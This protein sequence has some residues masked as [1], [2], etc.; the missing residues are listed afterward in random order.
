[1]FKERMGHT[2]GY[3][4]VDLESRDSVIRREETNF[5]NMITDLM[6][7][8]YDADFGFCISGAFRKNAVIPEGPI[9]LMEIQ[10]SFPFNDATMVLEMPGHIVKEALEWAVS[11]YPSE[12]GRSPQVSGLQFW[13][14]P[15]KPVGRRICETE[16]ITKGQGNFDLNKS[17][18]VAMPKFMAMGGDGYSMFIGEEVETI[19]DEENGLGIIDIVK[20]FFKR[21]RT[22]Y[23][24]I[25]K[26]ELT[27]QMR[28]RV[29]HVDVE[30]EIDGVSPDGLYFKLYPQ[31]EG[32]ILVK[33]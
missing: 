16:I 15:E 13:F 14:D 1:M 5:G 30:D 3:V 26:R 7:T 18:R 20:Q 6:R 29:F 33:G 12:E 10:A 17:Y 23:Q 2:V 8:E 25:A 4:G 19:V 22:D 31:V 9:S 32:R 27:R 24:V 11:A 28:L 21:T